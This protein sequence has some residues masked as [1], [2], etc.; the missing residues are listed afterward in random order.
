MVRGRGPG[1][2]LPQFMADQY[3]AK[4]AVQAPAPE[5]QDHYCEGT[6]QEMYHEGGNYG[7]QIDG[8][9]DHCYENYEQGYKQADDQY[10][11]DQ[12]NG[13]L[14]DFDYLH[15]E[16]FSVTATVD[17]FLSVE[18]SFSVTTSKAKL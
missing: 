7:G 18:D 15:D 12:G 4:Q 10:Y 14:H 13:F 3:Y 2:Q 11:E 8:Y 16:E 5:E 9:Q 17:M 6:R 1:P